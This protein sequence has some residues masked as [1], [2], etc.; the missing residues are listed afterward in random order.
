MFHSNK[1]NL[2]KDK[3]LYYKIDTQSGQ[4]GSPVFDENNRL[5][6]VGIHKGH[7]PDKNFNTAVM[8]TSEII[9]VL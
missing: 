5:K 3:I 2:I 7:S 9:S 4:S 6:L 8:I 1:I